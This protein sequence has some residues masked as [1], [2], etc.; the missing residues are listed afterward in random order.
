MVRSVPCSIVQQEPPFFIESNF[1][2]YQMG[3]RI[4]RHRV[5]YLI[6]AP[7]HYID[8][9]IRREFWKEDGNVGRI[10]GLCD[11]WEFANRE[12]LK[13]QRRNSSSESE[14]GEYTSTETLEL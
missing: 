8:R 14:P 2:V 1:A 13:Q 11:G 9:K 3:S 12:T 6:N 7:L 4:V 10:V 5:I